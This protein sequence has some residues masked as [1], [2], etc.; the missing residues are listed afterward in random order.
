MKVKEIETVK[1][2]KG[3]KEKEKEKRKRN[4]WEEW[5]YILTLRVRAYKGFK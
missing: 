4:R 5:K 1:K 2:G 3:N